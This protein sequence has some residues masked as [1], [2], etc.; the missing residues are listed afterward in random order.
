M[1][2]LQIAYNHE[3]RSARKNSILKFARL[4]DCKSLIDLSLYKRF[5]KNVLGKK[6]FY[7][8]EATI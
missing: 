5:V 2:N 3:T 6:E 1:D 4:C 7:L 8:A